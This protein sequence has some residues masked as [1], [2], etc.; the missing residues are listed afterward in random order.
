MVLDRR[1]V[2]DATT[3]C[4][5]GSVHR[6][7]QLTASYEMAVARA[8]HPRCKDKDNEVRTALDLEMQIRALIRRLR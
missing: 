6:V 2:H 8:N 5:G 4:G 7:V 1:L 3:R